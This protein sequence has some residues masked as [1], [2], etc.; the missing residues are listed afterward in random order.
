M[1]VS[2]VTS[3]FDTAFSN[4]NKNNHNFNDAPLKLA[5]FDDEMAFGAVWSRM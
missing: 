4:K 3:N 2:S 1:H 5:E